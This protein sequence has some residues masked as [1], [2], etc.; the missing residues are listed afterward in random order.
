[1]RYA[2]LF[3]AALFLGP[4]IEAS[5]KG[6]DGGNAP[7]GSQV[8]GKWYNPDQ[9]GVQDCCTADADVKAIE[10]GLESPDSATQVLADDALKKQLRN[11]L[12]D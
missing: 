9:G 12:D 3:I 11:Q 6:F 8:K 2:I 10:L 5:A 7:G 1:M 4:V